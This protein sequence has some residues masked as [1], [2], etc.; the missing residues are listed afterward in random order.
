MVKLQTALAERIS[1]LQEALTHIKTLQGLLPICSYCH[2]IRNDGEIWQQ[3]EGYIEDH[4]EAEFSH[5]IC[6]ECLEKY[7][8]EDLK[9]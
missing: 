6:P 4:S 2:K 9:L 1:E 8:S 7:H 3:I 5:S